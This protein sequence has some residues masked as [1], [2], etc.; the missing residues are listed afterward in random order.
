VNNL[1][2]SGADAAV[3]DCWFSAVSEG[4]HDPGLSTNPVLDV[5][6]AV[7]DGVR[8]DPDSTAAGVSVR[9]E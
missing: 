1:S 6:V 8:L 9:S 7:N 5:T 2:L 3:P 4:R